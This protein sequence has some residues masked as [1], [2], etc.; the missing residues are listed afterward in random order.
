MSH[1]D[2][3]E[4]A[5]VA[6]P[7]EKWGERPLATVVLREG[8]TAD[9]ASLRAF[10]AEE[11]KIAKWQLPERWTIVEAVP[12]TSVGKFDKK[13]LHAA[14][15][16]GRPGRD[17]ALTDRAGRIATPAPGGRLTA[18]PGVPLSRPRPRPRAPAPERRA[19]PE[20]SPTCSVPPP[21][22]GVG[23]ARR[24]VRGALVGT[25]AR[26]QVDDPVLDLVARGALGEEQH[27]L[28]AASRGSSAGST[29]AV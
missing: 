8:S 27:G 25:D 1:P 16:R 26:Q 15:R 3:A 23:C 21:R 12:K 9:F 6:V 19:V 7:D 10:L 4:A 28:P 17:P 2:V 29:A 20:R 24:D 22:R 13:V 14:V 11:G 18:L 5:V